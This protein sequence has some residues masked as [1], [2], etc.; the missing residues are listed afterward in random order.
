MLQLYVS[1]NSVTCYPLQALSCAKKLRHELPIICKEGPLLSDVL[2]MADVLLSWGSVGHRYSV[3]DL[4]ARTAIASELVENDP[5]ADHRTTSLSQVRQESL[6][7]LHMLVQ[8][9]VDLLFSHWGSLLLESGSRIGLLQIVARDKSAVCRRYAAYTAVCFLKSRQVESW[10]GTI[11]SSR[12]PMNASST[13]D[14]LGMLLEMVSSFARTNDASDK[15]TIVRLIRDVAVRTPWKNVENASI[16]SMQLLQWI[17]DVLPTTE[18]P[19][20]ILHSVPALLAQA[21]P[22]LS[23]VSAL[24]TEVIACTHNVSLVNQVLHELLKLHPTCITS[25]TEL[26]AIFESGIGL[27]SGDVPGRIATIMNVS[28]LSTLS[29]ELQNFL[30]KSFCVEWDVQPFLVKESLIFVIGKVTRRSV[31][32][33]EFVLQSLSAWWDKVRESDSVKSTQAIGDILFSSIIWGV[34]DEPVV[35][36]LLFTELTVRLN[37]PQPGSALRAIMTGFVR[38]S[39]CPPTTNSAVFCRIIHST[40]NRLLSIWDD[41]KCVDDRVFADT[42]RTVGLVASV[43]GS[44]VNEHFNTRSYSECIN[45][46]MSRKTQR[47][48]SALVSLRQ[49]P[50][51]STDEV[52]RII[53]EVVQETCGAITSHPRMDYATAPTVSGQLHVLSECTKMLPEI[54]IHVRVS[55]SAAVDFVSKSGIAKFNK[56]IPVYSAQL[57]R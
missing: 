33:T 26:T 13:G 36:Q 28:Y 40:Q 10:P 49:L 1:S 14:C 5:V 8:G 6:K 2:Q 51:G 38:I 48:L 22:D 25:T 11:I 56:D 7:C 55:L 18:E 32:N 42:I 54:P 43:Q 17:M 15:L 37:G 19:Q 30:N 23:F 46:L 9:N 52:W 4:S 12:K 20:T 53:H 50:E 44:F 24:A 3:G 21:R 35:D 41:P 47:C 31:A 39:E 45:A 34:I 27:P 29:D 16:V 57:M